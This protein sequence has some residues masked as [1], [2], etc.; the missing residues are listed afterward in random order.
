[1][2]SSQ[3][4][5][6]RIAIGYHPFLVDAP[7][8]A[9]QIARFLQGRGVQQVISAPMPDKAFRHQI[10]D[11]K[12]DL[13]IAL[14]GDG[15]MLRAGHLGAQLGI[16][17]LGINLGR[18]G[19]LMEVQRDEWRELLPRLLDGRYRLENRMMLRAEHLRGEQSLGCWSV[20]NEV[21]VCRGQFVRPVRLKAS[22]DGYALATY[23]ADGLIVATPTGSTAYALAVGGPILPPDLRNILIVAVAPHLSLDR[24]IILSEGSVVTVTVHTSHQAVM[25]VDGQAP[26][27]MEDGDAVRVDALPEMVRFVRFQDYGYF[28]RNLTAYMEQNPAAEDLS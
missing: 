16:P 23:I 5:P 19:F 17:V 20:L 3:L 22:V 14:G 7:Q 10:R 9:E 8:E 4:I 11:G 6:Q 26:I 18:F 15:T 21:V 12:F 13:L 25:S 27:T 2:E 1:M 24:A 28:Y